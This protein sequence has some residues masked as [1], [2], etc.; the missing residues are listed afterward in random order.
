MKR[1]M[2]VCLG[3]IC[4]SPMAEFV[5]KDLIKKKNIEHKYI[6]ASS[7]TSSDEIYMGVGNPVYPPAKED[8][9]KH[10]ISC[11]GKRA[12]QLTVKDYEKYDLFVCMDNSNV[13][14][15]IRIFNG[16]PQNKVKLLL[17]YACGGEVADPWYYGHFDK[18]YKDVLTGC[19]ALLGALEE[20]E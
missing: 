12:V 6:V 16:D 19:T 17:D 14:N 8:L 18:T 13:K 5:F 1:I 7:A 15:T 2:F 3:N 4:R 20:S 9:K 11:E 10:G